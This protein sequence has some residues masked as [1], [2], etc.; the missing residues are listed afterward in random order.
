M[1]SPHPILPLPTGF[2]TRELRTKE[3]RHKSQPRLLSKKG[4]QVNANVNYIV[5]I[6]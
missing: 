4:S 1:S 5:I 2:L 6:I 3:L